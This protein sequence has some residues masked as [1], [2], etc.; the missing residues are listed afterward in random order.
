MKIQNR[1]AI[2][3][4]AGVLVVIIV[5]VVSL[6]GSVVLEVTG[7]Y[8]NPVGKYIGQHLGLIKQTFASMTVQLIAPD[9]T[10]TNYTNNGPVP[11]TITVAGVT[12]L[13]I[14]FTPNFNV[15]YTGGTLSGFAISATWSAA[16]TDSSVPAFPLSSWNSADT[17]SIPVTS[18]GIGGG[19]LTH[20]CVSASSLSIGSTGTYTLTA[21]VSLQATAAFTDGSYSS[22]SGSAT[23][24]V[25]YTYSSGTITTFSVTIS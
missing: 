19:S 3:S 11:L 12:E 21:S 24:S 1:R 13:E 23:A 6:A 4:G 20:N 16:S 14:C 22:K 17:V 2:S 15:A 18:S 7:A 25:I 5:V 10:V 8:Q 9:G